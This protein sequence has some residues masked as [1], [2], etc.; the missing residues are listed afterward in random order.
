MQ[1]NM[2]NACTV[3]FRTAYTQNPNDWLHWVIVGPI[4][5]PHVPGGNPARHGRSGRCWP[6]RLDEEAQQFHTAPMAK[7]KAML[8]G[9]FTRLF[10]IFG[11]SLL[12]SES[13]GGPLSGFETDVAFG[14]GFL[15]RC[16]LVH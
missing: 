16:P 8:S 10:R 13:I 1:R 2:L 9:R 14:V 6:R 12:P 15:S 11:K 4:W 7:Q 5:A 3:G